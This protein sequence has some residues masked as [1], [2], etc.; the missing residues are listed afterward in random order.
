MVLVGCGTPRW[1]EEFRASWDKALA[2]GTY[3]YDDA[4]KNNG[5]ATQEQ[6]LSDGSKVCVWKSSRFFAVP[7]GYASTINESLKL[8]F[9][10][11]NVL[12]DWSCQNLQP[13]GLGNLRP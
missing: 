8:T 12:T 10:K 6:T 13:N 1:G 3:T 4:I 7:Q 5:P 11:S 2:S 9:S